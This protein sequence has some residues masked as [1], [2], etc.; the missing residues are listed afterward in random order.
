MN[1][2]HVFGS[3]SSIDRD[4]LVFVDTLPTLEESKIIAA[5]LVPIIQT[6][7][8][9]AKKPNINF[10]ILDDGIVV[11]TLK[12]IADETNNAI[13]ATYDFHIQPYPLA[14][15]RPVSRDLPAKYQR[16][17][18]V[19]LSLYSRTNHRQAV[20]QALRG[21]FAAR[22]AMLERIDF[23]V[24]VA[25]FGKHALPDDVYKSIA[26]Q[27]GQA[28]SLAKGIELYTKEDIISH[29]PAFARALRREP[30]T[31]ECRQ[32][33]EDAKQQFLVD[34]SSIDPIKQTSTNN[35]ATL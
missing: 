7:F 3:P 1:I 26:F 14:I 34:C 31:L 29:F 23:S 13:L 8:E 35:P 28:I 12:G 32:A 25:D 22:C 11:E 27:L 2:F 4:I 24:H 21:D 33:L 17:A 5:D 18:R 15:T 30:L 19:I 16:T 6:Y 10:G 9:D 20:K